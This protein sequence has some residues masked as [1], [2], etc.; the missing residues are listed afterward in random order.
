[1][2]AA[3]TDAWKEWDDRLA[4]H[5]IAKR[6]WQL[7]F[8]AV[9]LVALALAVCVVWLSARIRYVA[10]VVAVDRL[11]YAVAQA[12]PLAPQVSPDVVTRMMRYEV[13]LFI[14]AARSVS[15][16]PEVEQQALNNLLAHTVHLSAADRF[17]DGYYHDN[18]EARN[19]FVIA[20]H[21]TVNVQIESILP[22]S[23]KTWEVRWHEEARDLNGAA[24]GTPEHWEAQLTTELITPKDSDSIL[25]NPLGFYV[26]AIA[27]TRAQDQ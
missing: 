11:G 24:L 13:A 22:L 5:V 21:R 3:Y 4:D 20:M 26:S 12:Q 25:S 10:Y 14:R 15:N 2:A 23:A 8:G 17:L 27:W 1:M 16:D 18:H 9:A 7:A 19:P 6:N